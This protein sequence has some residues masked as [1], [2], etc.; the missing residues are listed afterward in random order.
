MACGM[1][2][3][4]NFLFLDSCQKRFLWTHKEI[5]LAPQPVV[6]PVFQVGNTEKFPPALC[7]ESLDPFFRVSK[8]GPCF[9][10][11]Y[12]HSQDSNIALPFFFLLVLDLSMPSLAD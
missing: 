7:F 3:P 2:E 12:H 4:C 11:C 5:D 1:P 9:T 6:G 8:Q 10:A